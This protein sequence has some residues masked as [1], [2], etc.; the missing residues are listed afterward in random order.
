MPVS[1]TDYQYDHLVLFLKAR[2]AALVAVVFLCIQRRWSG[3]YREVDF[4]IMR[5]T[6]EILLRLSFG[7]GGLLAL[8]TRKKR[9]IDQI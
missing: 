9:V 2:W 6:F 4:M 8:R 7:E 1:K 3:H 5:T